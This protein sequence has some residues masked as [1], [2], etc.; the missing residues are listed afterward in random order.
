MSFFPIIPP[1]SAIATLSSTAQATDTVDA[2]TFTFSGV[3][4]GTPSGDRKILVGVSVVRASF[5]T[6]ITSMTIGGISATEIIE[7]DS[8][9]EAVAIYIASV[10]TGTTGD[11]VVVCA[12]TESNCGIDVYACTGM[13]STAHATGGSTADPMTA[14][15]AIPAGGVAIGHAMIGDG[16][17]SGSWTNLTENQDD[18]VESNGTHM[19][20][21]DAF[22]LI[23]SSLALTCTPAGTYTRQAAA[24]ASFGPE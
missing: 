22:A 19:G 6:T 3:A 24:F 15:L 4:L 11:I 7:Q 20:A 21:A 5:P 17:S 1:R 12:H 16:V 23:Q 8:T 18:N 14:S 2:S 9:R 10:P 13:S